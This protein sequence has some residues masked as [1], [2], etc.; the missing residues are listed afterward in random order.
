MI[1]SVAVANNLPYI[2]T[3]FI[4]F[5]LLWH[6]KLVSTV[7]SFWFALGSRLLL[8][9]FSECKSYTTLS[10]ANRKETY[11]SLSYICDNTLKP[12]WFR[13][14]GDAGT[15]MPTWCVPTRRCGAAIP[16]WLNGTHPAENED[17]V[18]RQ[19]HF[20]WGS[21]CHY[22]SVDIQ[23]KNCSGYYVYYLRETGC[24][25]RS[26]GTDREGSGHT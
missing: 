1:T 21:N 19:V 20:H 2:F 24:N 15:K 10:S 8:I 14:Q 16:G 6:C 7:E 22:W 9:Y 18:A 3:L 12:G 17:I 25:A 4:Y 5:F 11:I 13:F 26:C 23:V